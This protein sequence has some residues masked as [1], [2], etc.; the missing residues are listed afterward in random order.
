ML[1]SS[2][3][4]QYGLKRNRIFLFA[5]LFNI[6]RPKFTRDFRIYKV[7]GRSCDG[8]HFRGLSPHGLRR[9]AQHAAGRGARRVPETQ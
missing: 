6:N 3:Y 8:P 2:Q 1:Y 7:P 4:S 9:A 5:E